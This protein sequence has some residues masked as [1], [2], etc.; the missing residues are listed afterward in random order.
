MSEK[1]CD[2]T[3]FEDLR[4]EKEFTDVTLACADCQL[5]EA[6]KVILTGSS[7]QNKHPNPLIWAGWVLPPI[8]TFQLR[9]EVCSVSLPLG[10]QQSRANK[11]HEQLLRNKI[12]PRHKYGWFLLTNPSQREREIWAHV[13][14]SCLEVAPLC[15]HSQRGKFTGKWCWQWSVVFI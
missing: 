1:L 15:L 8:K 10:Y 2:F 7:S 13:L 14:P 3:F 12:V 6:H 5:R 9:M 11:Y 4:D